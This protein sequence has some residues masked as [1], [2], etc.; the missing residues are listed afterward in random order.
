M[1]DFAWRSYVE[2]TGVLYGVI[3]LQGGYS[4]VLSVNT[5]VGAAWYVVG[6][7]L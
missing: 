5:V 3:L 1:Q 6:C 4:K 2:W 7:E